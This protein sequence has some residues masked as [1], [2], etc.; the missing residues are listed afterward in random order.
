MQRQAMSRSAPRIQTQV[1]ERQIPTDCS[2]S[3]SA[4]AFGRRKQEREMK[5]EYW[6]T[7]MKKWGIENANL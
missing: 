5:S 7:E 4:A 3:V 1:R 2:R 6:V